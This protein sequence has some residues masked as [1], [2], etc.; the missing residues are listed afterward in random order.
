MSHFNHM[1][2]IQIAMKAHNLGTVKISFDLK[3]YSH[4]CIHYFIGI[5]YILGER[6]ADKKLD[7]HY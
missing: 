5:L 3:A 4:V 1:L 6:I 2:S 7:T